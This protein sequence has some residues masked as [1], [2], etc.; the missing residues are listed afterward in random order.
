[1]QIRAL[2][3]V[4]MWG[5]YG[6]QFLLGVGK[7][8]GIFVI[9]VLQML[10][11]DMVRFVAL[12]TIM[13]FAFVHSFY[14]IKLANDSTILASGGTVLET[15]NMLVLKAKILNMFY[16]GFIGEPSDAETVPASNR[17]RNFYL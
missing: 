13:L 9:M 2:A 11:S 8:T 3:V 4:F 12:F 7:S 10:V 15:S 5:G 1:V 16:V 14:L 6:L 17:R